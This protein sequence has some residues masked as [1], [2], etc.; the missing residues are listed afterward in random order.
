[1]LKIQVNEKTDG[2]DR[3]FLGGRSSLL[4]TIIGAFLIAVYGYST[5]LALFAFELAISL[6][7]LLFLAY[8]VGIGLV[9]IGVTFYRH[10]AEFI[11]L[12]LPKPYLILGLALLTASILGHIFD[13]LK[14][15]L[16]LEY[17][18]SLHSF[19]VGLLRGR[20]FSSPVTEV[21]GI[22][23]ALV[24]FLGRGA[25][26]KFLRTSCLFRVSNYVLA[27][28]AITSLMSISLTISEPLLLSEPWFPFSAPLNVYLVFYANVHSLGVFGLT[29]GWASLTPIHLNK[30]RFLVPT[31]YAAFLVTMAVLLLIPI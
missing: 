8:L 12:A 31:L 27:L 19:L 14:L 4:L 22:T 9:I 23:G 20:S 3:L 24:L 1:M 2:A 25:C 13:T 5:L 15:G 30:Y 10:S 26:S 21:L 11:T 6:R 28:G 7:W 16:S 29:F 18:F 17:P